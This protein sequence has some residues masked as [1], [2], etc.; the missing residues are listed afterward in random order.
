MKNYP[1]LSNNVDNL[2]D[3][4]LQ[5]KKC[6]LLSNSSGWSKQQHLNGARFHRRWG[7]GSGLESHVRRRW[8]SGLGGQ[9][10]PRINQTIQGFFI[11][12]IASVILFV[13]LNKAP[14]EPMF[15]LFVGDL[16]IHC[17]SLS[18]IVILFQASMGDPFIIVCRIQNY[19]R[20]LAFGLM[21]CTPLAIDI[22]GTMQVFYSSV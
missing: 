22:I 16:V 1:K 2:D 4:N 8:E 20:S 6:F 3:K 13:L 10:H 19:C 18:A 12:I 14:L 11:C 15:Q 7:G 17:A 9:K 5:C 21:S